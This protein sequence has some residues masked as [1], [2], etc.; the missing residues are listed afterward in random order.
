MTARM[1]AIEPDIKRIFT[2]TSRFFASLYRDTIHISNI[3]TLGKRCSPIVGS[4]VYRSNS[5]G[6]IN[7]L[8]IEGK[9]IYENDSVSRRG[10]CAGTLPHAG[11]WGLLSCGHRLRARC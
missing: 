4:E 5:R 9:S 3:P 7:K 11:E 8:S 1:H 10:F 6:L 2:E